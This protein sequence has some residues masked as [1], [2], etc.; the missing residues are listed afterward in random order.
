VVEDSGAGGGSR[1]VAGQGWVVSVGAW[2][3]SGLPVQRRGVRT[4]VGCWG[5]PGYATAD[6]VAMGAPGGRGQVILSISAELAQAA[7]TPGTRSVR[8]NGR[9]GSGC[10]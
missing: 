3:R 8:G 6:T 4:G 2:A 5:P 7:Q 10:S 1:C 9:G